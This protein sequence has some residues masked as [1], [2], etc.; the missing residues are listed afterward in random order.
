MDTFPWGLVI[1][2]KEMVK[3]IFNRSYFLGSL[4][5]LQIPFNS[6]SLFIMILSLNVLMDKL[7]SLCFSFLIYKMEIIIPDSE[8][9]WWC[10]KC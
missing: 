4:C 3:L 8:G 6:F 7:T 1:W 5:L 10:S 2:L 9:G